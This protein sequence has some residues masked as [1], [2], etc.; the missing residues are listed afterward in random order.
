[1]TLNDENDD[2]GRGA[3]RGKWGEVTGGGRP[4]SA[5][6]RDPGGHRRPERRTTPGT[7]ANRAGYGNRDTPEAANLKNDGPYRRVNSQLGES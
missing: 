1:M 3:E 6:T 7:G 5:M 4:S 2:L